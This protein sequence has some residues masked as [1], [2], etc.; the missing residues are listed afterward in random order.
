MLIEQRT[1]GYLPDGREVVLV[2]ITNESGSYIELT[3]YGATWVSAF[4]PDSNG[5]MDDVILG[6]PSLEGYI[7]DSCYI[8]STIGRFANRIGSAHFSIGEQEYKLETNDGLNTNH[9]GLSGFNK[10]L[11]NFTLF[12]SGIC[13]SLFSPDGEGGYPGNLFVE[14]CYHFSEDNQVTINYKGESDKRTYLNLTNHAYFNLSGEKSVL[15]HYLMIPSNTILD[16]TKDYIPTGQFR[17]IRNSPFDF[18]SPVK[19][20]ARIFEKEVQLEWNRGYN[21]CY[22]LNQNDSKGLALAAILSDPVSGRELEVQTTLPS[23][24]A[25]TGNYLETSIQGKK[26]AN[27]DP[28]EGVCIEAQF[29]PDTPNHSQFP[30]CLIFPGNI[31]QEVIVFTFRP[32]KQ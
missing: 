23:V 12:N 10:K 3:N 29:F 1:F 8:G 31:Y 14:V 15:N 26:G 17:D 27:Y 32:I 25:Y 22:V 30:S 19:L 2:R 24:L 18:T 13:F 6:Y 5:Q 20:G 4:V 9:G 28:Y 11:W 21:H 16:T 7:S